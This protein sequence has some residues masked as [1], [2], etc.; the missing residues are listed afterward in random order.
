MTAP[1]PAQFSNN[2][3]VVTEIFTDDKIDALNAKLVERG[4]SADQV[5]RRCRACSYRSATAAILDKMAGKP[6]RQA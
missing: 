5:E 1:Q 4:I 3:N 2:P 6:V